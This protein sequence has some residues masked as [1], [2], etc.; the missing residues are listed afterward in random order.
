MKN[1]LSRVTDDEISGSMAHQAT[2]GAMSAALQLVTVVEI[3][4]LQNAL[5]K[6]ALPADFET[7][8]TRLSQETLLHQ[9]VEQNCRC[10]VALLLAIQEGSF[11]DPHAMTQDRLLRVLAYVRKEQD[12]VP[13]FKPGGFMDDWREVRA[14]MSDLANVIQRFKVWKLRHQVPG[15]WDS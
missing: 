5:F 7:K 15:M 13:D 11:A 10:F 6:G 3:E 1:D 4:Q 12:Q 14:A 9:S 2:V 8:L